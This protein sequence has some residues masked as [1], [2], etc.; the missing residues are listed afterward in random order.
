M[1]WYSPGPELGCLGTAHLLPC[2]EATS[3][4]TPPSCVYPA[5]LR[6]HTQP[7]CP[8]NV[9]PSSPP[10]CPAPTRCLK[11][12]ALIANNLCCPDNNNTKRKRLQPSAK[13]KDSAASQAAWV[14][15]ALLRVCFC[16]LFQTD[17]EKKKKTTFCFRRF[18]WTD[19]DK[20]SGTSENSARGHGS[21]GLIAGGL[22]CRGAA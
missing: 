18:G 4:L 21:H 22:G 16:F 19:G 15:P 12:L 3:A 14:P 1:G 7:G 2:H 9:R 11:P 10:P 17:I 13:T 20:A 8:P 6:I 5:S